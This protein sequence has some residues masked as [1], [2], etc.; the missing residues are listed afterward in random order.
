MKRYEKLARLNGA[1]IRCRDTENKEWY[2]NHSDAIVEM[3]YET[4]PS[5]SGFDNGT[6]FNFEQ[7]TGEKLVF[8]A[9]YHHMNGDGM[10]CGWS[11]HLV[12][13]TPSL[14][15]GFNIKVTGQNKNDIKN[16]IV[17]VFAEWLDEDIED[18]NT[19]YVTA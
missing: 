8:E 17:D 13:I 1:R 14:Q 5:G 6:H 15:F 3:M 16:Y 19:A 4:A 12:K 9:G 2:D 10:Y 7:S 11:E 18:M